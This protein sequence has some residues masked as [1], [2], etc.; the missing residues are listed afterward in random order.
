MTRPHPSVS[1]P[2]NKYFPPKSLP[3]MSLQRTRLV[4]IMAAP[5]TPHQFIFLEAQAGQGKTTVAAQL[6]EQLGLPFLWYQSG[7]EDRDPIVFLGCL[8]NGFRES[9][10]GFASPVP[11]AQLESGQADLVDLPQL[12]Q[13]FCRDLAA[14]LAQ[15]GQRNGQ[16]AVLVLDDVH[17]LETSDK[18]LGLLD[19]LLESLPD[20]LAVMLLSRS[21]VPLQSKRVRFGGKTLYLSNKE[22]AMTRDEGVELVALLLPALPEPI[23][24]NSLL[25]QAGGWPMGL[26]LAR[27]I[28]PVKTGRSGGKKRPAATWN[29]NS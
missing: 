15:R 21:P 1:I 12:L 11:Q 7:P 10:K 19:F 25:Q 22:L 26:V 4:Q 16:A 17:L 18:S 5:P 29:G 20:T 2:A 24:L 8:L 28:P 23:A 3:G 14:D 6:L 13:A 9:L 27:T